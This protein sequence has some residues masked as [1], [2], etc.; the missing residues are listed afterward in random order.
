MRSTMTIIK[1][2]PQVI[3]R[4][5]VCGFTTQTDNENQNLISYCE[6][7]VDRFKWLKRETHFHQPINS[8]P[9]G[10]QIVTTYN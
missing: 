9:Q 3:K 7:R 1:L 8:Y 10:F 4:R 5:L 2:A 6:C